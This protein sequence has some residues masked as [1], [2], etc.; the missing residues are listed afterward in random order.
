MKLK[1]PMCKAKSVKVTH[2]RKQVPYGRPRDTGDMLC[3]EC[4]WKD[5]IR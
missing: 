1:C 3:E 4:G 2:I 5:L